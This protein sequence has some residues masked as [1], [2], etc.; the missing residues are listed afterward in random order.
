MLCYLDRSRRALRTELLAESICAE[1][2]R[3]LDEFLRATRALTELLNQQIQAA[4]HNDPDFS[5]FDLLLQLAQKRKEAAK[6]AWMGQSRTI[7]A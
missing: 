1:K 6:Y 4:I 5:R 3:L 7:V 2:T